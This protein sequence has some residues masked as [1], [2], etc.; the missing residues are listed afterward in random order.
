MS[1]NNKRAA[2]V[3][4]PSEDPE[5][6]ACDPKLWRLDPEA[7]FLNHGSFGSCPVRV[8][9][10][11]QALRDR[12]ERQPV[13]F[14][15]RDLEGLLDQARAQL[16]QFVGA[17]PEGLVFIANA[18]AGVNTVLRSLDWSAG[19]ELLV[20]NHEYNACRN[21][22][23]HVAGRSGAKVVEVRIPFPLSSA[24]E[25]VEAVCGAVTT[26]TRLALLD[27]VTSQ[28]GL[29]LPIRRL[30]QELAERG[31]ETLV[32]GA[33][34]PGMVPLKLSELGAA[35]YTGN[36]HK[37]LCAPKGA[38]FLH[39]RD[40]RQTS[41]RPL[42]ISHGANSP[43]LDRSRYLIEFGWTGT[44]DP[45]AFLAVPEALRYM[46][47]LLPGGWSEL[48]RRNRE[49]VL[50]GREILCAALQI[51]PPCPPEL[52]G[53]LASVPVP[54]GAAEPSTS[55]LYMDPWQ[56]VLWAKHSIEVPIIPWPAP[57]KRLL[58]ISAQAYNDVAQYRLLAQTVRGLM[59]QGRD[60]AP[61]KSG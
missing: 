4:S 41:I 29:V 46:G 9:E 32:D 18:T 30:V 23:D 53:A 44:L 17:A 42:S 5:A 20:T 24:E 48:M 61:G 56:E 57:P 39:V 6:P 54:D 49:L 12:L 55:P 43:R 3:T 22:L 8:L 40:D 10:F 60:M 47:S 59:V 36:C 16:A 38:A 14:F 21:A 13:K 7:V 50:W 52:I 58:R 28:T 31:V 35:Y 34:A 26:R 19:D 45:T 25:I 33:H 37:W 27:H 15:V 1:S 11:Q 51:P 2:R